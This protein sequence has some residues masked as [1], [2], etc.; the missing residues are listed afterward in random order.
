MNM[1]AS[2]SQ[3]RY[4]NTPI[5]NQ[6]TTWPQFGWRYCTVGTLYMFLYSSQT[7]HYRTSNPSTSDLTGVYED[8]GYGSGTTIAQY[9]RRYTSLRYVDFRGS[10]S[11]A[12]A[13]GQLTL[14][15][16]VPIGV[17][18]WQGAQYHVLGSNAGQGTGRAAPVVGQAH[19]RGSGDP[20]P[21]GHWGLVIGYDAS[22]FYINDPDSGTNI[23]WAK[24][25]FASHNP[26]HVHVSG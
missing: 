15:F 22:Y 8:N 19:A 13:E 10:C 1:P 2:T 6:H 17:D 12:Q 9:I 14:G 16:P 26:Y 20:Y 5:I 23:R 4:Y 24:S 3:P 11:T 25:S 18:H 7:Q 21:A